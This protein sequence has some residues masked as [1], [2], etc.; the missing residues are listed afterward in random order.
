[1]VVYKLREGKEES[2]GS[3]EIACLSYLAVAEGNLVREEGL[4]F[5]R[6]LCENEA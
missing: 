2:C 4:Y 5:E 3:L 1:M 6:Q